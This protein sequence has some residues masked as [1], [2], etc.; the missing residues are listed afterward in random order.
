MFRRV[1]KILDKLAIELAPHTACKLIFKNIY[2]FMVVGV[3][4]VHFMC[5]LDPIAATPSATSSQ[6]CQK[7]TVSRSSAAGP[8]IAVEGF[9]IPDSSLPAPAREVLQ[10][11]QYPALVPPRTLTVH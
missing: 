6:Q 2:N 11:Y 3:G 8:R 7:P 10:T 5:V 9:N 4:V 1:K